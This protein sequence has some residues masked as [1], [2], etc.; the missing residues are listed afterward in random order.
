MNAVALGEFLRARRERLRP[1]DVGLSRGGPRR[2]PGLRRE[3]VSQLAN[4]SNNYYER[5]EQARSAQPS[6]SM[7]GSIAR[8]LRLTLDERDHLYTLAGHHPPSAH[9]ALG[10]ADPGLMTLLDAV[11]RDV[12]ALVTD[13]LSTVLAQNPL[14]VALLGQLAGLPG[15]E[16]NFTWHWFTDPRYRTLYAENDRSS[17]SRSYVA[18][19][20]ITFGRRGDDPDALQLVDDLL[21]ASEEFASLWQLNEV[22]RRQSTRKVIQ[23]PIVGRLDCECDVVISPPSGQRLVIFRGA[24]TTGTSERLELLRVVGMQALID[25]NL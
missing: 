15:N 23:H 3:E 2:T 5:L 14:G 12:P 7:L 17:L 24:P 1:E 8:A 25:E 21:R 16:A 11:S 13:D 22:A 4:M 10:F 9:T 18:D 20:R 6:P 19:L